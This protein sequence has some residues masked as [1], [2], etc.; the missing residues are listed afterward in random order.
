MSVTASGEGV[1]LVGGW[2]GD[3][4][5]GGLTVEGEALADVPAVVFVEEELE[6]VVGV[7]DGTDFVDVVDEVALTGRSVQDR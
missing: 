4:E 1:S 2:R 3:R 5:K 6:V 7:V